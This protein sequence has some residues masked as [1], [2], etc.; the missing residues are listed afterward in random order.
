VPNLQM[1]DRSHLHIPP[2]VQEDWVK[3]SPLFAK[4]GPVMD[5][6]RERKR[7]RNDMTGLRGVNAGNIGR[8]VIVPKAEGSIAG[9]D[10]GIWDKGDLFREAKAELEARASPNKTKNGSIAAES[11]QRPRPLQGF[12]GVLPTNDEELNKLRSEKKVS[13]SPMW[14]VPTLTQKRDLEN[15]LNRRA[16]NLDKNVAVAINETEQ[17]TGVSIKALASKIKLSDDDDSDAE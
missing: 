1:G 6:Y 16:Y 14:N 13:K 12:A 5:M 11:R 10:Y 3:V 2:D 17:K 4:G 8:M 9:I 7:I 15:G